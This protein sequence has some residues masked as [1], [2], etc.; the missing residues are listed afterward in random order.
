MLVSAWGCFHGLVATDLPASH[1]YKDTQ[2]SLGTLASLGGQTVYAAAYL[3]Q[4]SPGTLC[5]FFNNRN[6]TSDA[7]VTYTVRCGYQGRVGNAAPYASAISTTSVKNYMSCISACDAAG[8][9]SCQHVNFQYSTVAEPSYANAAQSTLGLCTF[10]TGYPTPSAGPNARYAMAIKAS[11]ASTVSQVHGL[12]SSYLL[13]R[14]HRPPHRI[15]SR[16]TCARTQMDSKSP[17]AMAT[18]ICSNAPVTLLEGVS[19]PPAQ[20]STA[21][22][23]VFT[24]AARIQVS[25][26]PVQD[27]PI[28]AGRT[29]RAAGRA[30]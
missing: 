23:T 30:I 20:V 13:I 8:A 17:M 14:Y 29:A 16:H 22:M 15:Q 3:L 12:A 10:V 24:Y 4:A 27:L 19:T 18:R 5:P 1:F 25:R 2:G 6:F 7:G 11:A 21:S 28:L 26:S 9:T